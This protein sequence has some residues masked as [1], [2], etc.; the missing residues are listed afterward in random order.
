MLTSAGKHLERPL[1]CLLPARRISVKS[2]VARVVVGVVSTRA[3]SVRSV[4]DA[5]V[6]RWCVN[7]AEH[8]FFSLHQDL[9]LS[10]DIGECFPAT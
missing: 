4:R 2:G 8:Y 3:P 6:A 5:C 9:N 10:D 1:T 7:K